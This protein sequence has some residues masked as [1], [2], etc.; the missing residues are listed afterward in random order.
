MPED[1]LYIQRPADEHGNRGYMVDY[2]YPIIKAHVEGEG[3]WQKLVVT[4]PEAFVRKWPDVQSMYFQ[5]VSPEAGP[6]RLIE[7]L[8]ELEVILEQHKILPE[9]SLGPGGRG[10]VNQGGVGISE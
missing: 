6:P 2:K 9:T 10:S 3:V 8:R 4:A 1:K 5:E 7:S